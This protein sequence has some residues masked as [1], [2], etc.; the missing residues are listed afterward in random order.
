MKTATI[1]CLE[2]DSKILW[3]VDDETQEVLEEVFQPSEDEIHS[4]MVRNGYREISPGYYVQVEMTGYQV[5]VDLNKLD[6]ATNV[7]QGEKG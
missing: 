7:E 2:P 4:D 3:L 1:K 6:L 5:R